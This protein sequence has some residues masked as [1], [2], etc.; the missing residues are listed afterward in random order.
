MHEHI[1]HPL[2]ISRVIGL[3]AIQNTLVL[4]DIGGPERCDE[5][6]TRVRGPWKTL[7]LRFG[8]AIFER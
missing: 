3:P 2:Q 6:D 7:N 1:L 8:E 5:R 4:A